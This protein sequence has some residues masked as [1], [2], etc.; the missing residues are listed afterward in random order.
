MSEEELKKKS[1][2]ISVKEGCSYS[3]M[4]G[5]GLRY[6][7]PY[8]LALG[9]NNS[10]IGLISS[11]PGL[12]GNLTQLYS[13]KLVERVPRKKLVFW[14]VFLQAILWLPLLFVGYLYFFMSLDLFMTSF[15][16]VVTYTAMIVAG[17]FAGPAWSSWM[18]DL[19]PQERLGRYFGMRNRMVNIFI[20]FC[21]LAAGWILDYFETGNVFIGFAILFVI[22][23]IGRSFSAYFFTRQY[24]PK[25]KIRDGYYF[26][27]FEFV[28]KMPSNNYGKFV[29][30]SSLISFSVAIGSP[31]LGVY[32]LKDLSL[33]YF[34][35]TLICLSSLIAT[36]IFM[37]L[38]GKFVDKY[39]NINTMK[40]TAFF[41]WLL[42]IAWFVPSIFNFSS[43]DL[44]VVYLFI[45]EI[46]S[47]FIWAGL[48]LALGNYV[49]CAVTRERMA[50][51]VA[52]SSL[53][54]AFFAFAGAMLG[55]FLSSIQGMIFGLKPLFF[56]FI[57]SAFFRFLFVFI[58]LPRIKEVRADSCDFSLKHYVKNF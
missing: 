17:A 28:K 16:L 49:Y 23:F 2:K 36:I 58:M 26:S 53:I 51:C 6:I 19:V 9:A 29:I 45:E 22:A 40:V 11:L 34:Q 10:V 43:L 15:L 39:G 21:M 41:I 14:S 55:G 35:Y 46:F 24:E 42:P 27:F 57:V 30:F 13:S 47:G 32:M 25:L 48:N 52:Y 38:W 33:N 54:G 12:L 20:L 4:D 7:T 8:A 31:F 37:P 50:L 5:F 3:F 18:R 44:I 1:L 56:V